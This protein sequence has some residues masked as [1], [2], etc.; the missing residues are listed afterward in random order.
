MSRRE[1]I[2]VT[3]ADFPGVLAAIRALDAAGYE[4]W[5]LATREGS[6]AERSR[7]A[8]RTIVGPDPAQSPAGFAEACA[9]AAQ[10]HSFS[11]VM[12]GTEAALVALADHAAR[13]PPEVP[14]GTPPPET[15][16]L[17][18]DKSALAGLA[19]RAGLQTPPTTVIT[20]AD[21]DGGRDLPFPSVLKPIRSD[22]RLPDGT[23]R[24]AGPRRVESP[25]ELRAA[26]EA[27]P[28]NEWL[29]QPY[30]G[31]RIYGVCG[32]AWHGDVVCSEH[33]VGSRIWPPDCGMVSYV[34]TIPVDRAL[35][36]A[37]RRFMASIGW[38]GIFQLQFLVA[39]ERLY[40][41]DLNPRIYISLALVVAAG[42]N[43]PAIWADLLLGREPK[44]TPYRVGYRWRSD[45]DDPR[46]L[47][48]AFR[49]GRRTAALAGALPRRRTVHAVFSVRD[50]LPVLTSLRKL[51][52]K[53]GGS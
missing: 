2:L 18:T 28:G 21:L 45:E 31:D 3:G 16:A 39:G 22:V 30:V 46:A 12:P 27:L 42:L 26:A 38:S 43:L 35:D 20:L 40:L 19:Q 1:A 4:A 13:F 53:A 25:N 17:A 24:H 37:V 47:V 44:V 23:L 32:V 8:R 34:E 6:Y 10:R 49:S 15:V 14:V 5:A 11:G 29:L 9:R 52:A 51:R 48:H 50:P 41:I 33:Q 36:D 7:A